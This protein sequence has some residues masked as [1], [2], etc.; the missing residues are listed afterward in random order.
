MRTI[1]WFRRDLR[2]HDNT[3]LIAALTESEAVIPVYILDD[4]LLRSPRLRGARI[5]WMLDALRQFDAELRERGSRLIVRR[6]HGTRGIAAEL[7]RLCRETESGAVFFNRDYSSYAVKRDTRVNEVLSAEGIAVRGFKDLVLHE[8]GEVRSDGFYQV[9]GA[10]KRAW[11]ALPKP[12]ELAESPRMDR[13]R[14]PES[15]QSIEIPTAAELGSTPAPQPIAVPGEKPACDRLEL[16][17]QSHLQLQRGAE[18]ARHRRYIDPES[19]HPV[20]HA[21]SAHGVLGGDHRPRCGI[22]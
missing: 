16:H 14:V 8:S 7:L 1:M 9:F 11:L 17:A 20:G 13:L 6:G 5:A 10:Y 4:Q 2:T 21:Q 3:A 15:V 18:H 12:A 22:W 19:V